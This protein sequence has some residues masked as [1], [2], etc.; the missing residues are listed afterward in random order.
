MSPPNE[1]CAAHSDFHGFVADV[2]NKVTS[3]EKNIQDM[4]LVL[5]TFKG[6]A[7]AYAGIGAL[8]ILICVPVITALLLKYVFKV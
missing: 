6:A 3:M 4:N 7:Q 1:L 2:D 5:A 8:V